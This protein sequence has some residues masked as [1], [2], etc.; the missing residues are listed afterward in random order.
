MQIFHFLSFGMQKRT[1]LM[2]QLNEPYVR[3][4]LHPYGMDE[5]VPEAITEDQILNL[6]LY[7]ECENQQ[8]DDDFDSFDEDLPF[9]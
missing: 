9:M 6:S 7:Q 2:T 5:M 8:E 4:Q 3:R 1:T